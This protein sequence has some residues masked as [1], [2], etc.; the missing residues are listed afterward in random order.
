M[1]SS[2]Q[3][4]SIASFVV[5]GLVLVGLLL[6]GLYFSKQRAERVMNGPSVATTDTGNKDKDKAA[7]NQEKPAE[8]P[9]EKT[10]DKPADK[11]AQEAPKQENKPTAPAPKPAPTTTNQ[12]APS[13][14]DSSL[15]R[16]APSTGPSHIASTGPADSMLMSTIVVSVIGL[17]AVGYVKSRRSFIRAAQSDVS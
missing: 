14:R 13:T 17:S 12:P 15:P 8:K 6:A 16:T 7:T 1:E 3:S 11:P 2:R 4:G 9:A 5:I 10:T